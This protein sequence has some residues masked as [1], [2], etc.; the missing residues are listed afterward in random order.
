MYARVRTRTHQ[1]AG[2]EGYSSGVEPSILRLFRPHRR[3]QKV[4]LM[5]GRNR[6]GVGVFQEV[7]CKEQQVRTWHV[8]RPQMLRICVDKFLHDDTTSTH[9]QLDALIGWHLVHRQRVYT[10]PRH[11]ERTK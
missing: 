5:S 1:R 9:T 8:S 7:Y 2:R 6:A 3:L 4:Q 11:Q 10:Q